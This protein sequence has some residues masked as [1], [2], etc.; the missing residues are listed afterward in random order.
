MT[1]NMNAEIREL[2]TDE[3][4]FV[5]GGRAGDD[6]WH[7]CGPAIQGGITGAVHSWSEVALG[8]D[9]LSLSGRSPK[10]SSLVNWGRPPQL[11]ALVIFIDAALQAADGGAPADSPV[12]S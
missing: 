12:D 5:S 3:L 8:P 1:T 4:D 9:F 2:T 10:R 11:A 7:S 6:F